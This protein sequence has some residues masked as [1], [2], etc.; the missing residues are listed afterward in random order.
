MVF[1]ADELLR[2]FDGNKEMV[3]ELII[4]FIEMFPN[5]YNNMLTAIQQGDGSR[6]ASAAQTFKASAANIRAETCRSVA[7][8]LELLGKMRDLEQSAR[9]MKKLNL[10]FHRFKKVALK[11]YLQ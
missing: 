1:N 3:R 6:L 4:L 11:Q 7:R 9:T 5:H 10:E 8:D 2:I